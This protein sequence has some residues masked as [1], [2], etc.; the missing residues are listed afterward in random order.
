MKELRLVQSTRRK[1]FSTMRSASCRS[2]SFA[3]GRCSRAEPG[4][5][6]YCCSKCT[7]KP[8]ERVSAKVFPYIDNAKWRAQIETGERAFRGAAS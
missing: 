7:S 1:A 8:Y 5:R 4:R 2:T 6:F 3:T